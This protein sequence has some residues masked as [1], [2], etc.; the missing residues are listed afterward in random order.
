MAANGLR[1][2]EAVTLLQN[3]SMIEKLEDLKS[4]TTHLVVHR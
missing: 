1:L 4:Y 2:A 3:Y